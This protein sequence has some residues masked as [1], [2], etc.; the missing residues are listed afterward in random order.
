[1]NILCDNP[2]P[3]CTPG[4]GGG[5][6]PID[7][8]NPFVNLSSETPDADVFIGRRYSIG[9]PPLGSTWYAVGCIGW[10]LSTVSQQAADLCAA[11]Q[12]VLCQSTN[13]PEVNPLTPDDPTNLVDRTVYYNNAQ[14]CDYPCP[15]GTAHRYTVAAG[16]FASTVNQETVDLMAYSYACNQAVNSRICPGDLYP[17]STCANAAYN[18]VITIL[19]ANLPITWTEVTPLPDGLF[20]TTDPSN[21]FISGTPTTPDNYTF[22]LRATDSQDNSNERTYAL[23]V[24]GISTS[25]PLPD[26]TQNSFYSE[27]LEYGG[28]PSGTVVWS[29]TAGTMPTGMTLDTA[30]GELSGTPTVPGLYLLTIGVT[31]DARTC[32]K[33][34]AIT[35]NSASGDCVFGEVTWGAPTYTWQLA[36]G[37]AN[38]GTVTGSAIAPGGAPFEENI[39]FTGTMPYTGSGECAKCTLDMTTLSGDNASVSIVITSDIDGVLLSQQ[40]DQTDG[41]GT[42]E[43]SYKIPASIGATLTIVTNFRG[44]FIDFGPG[45]GS[46]IG[47]ITFCQVDDVAAAIQDVVWTQTGLGGQ[48]PLASI[49][50]AA[51]IGTYDFTFNTTTQIDGFIEMTG[52]ICNPGPAYNITLTM[53]WSAS[54]SV[55][56]GPFTHTIQAKLTINATT[57][58]DTRDLVTGPFTD[59]VV[60]G[61]IPAN[62]TSTLSVNITLDCLPNTSINVVPGAD[63]T[64]TPLTPP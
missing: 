60:V 7:P 16:L 14:Y 55:L 8:D 22:T 20:L 36:S 1:M 62:S 56:G 45:T 35:V 23:N 58:T 27:I 3:T 61:T 29:V 38:G 50:M 44:G 4:P 30:T 43:F 51:G 46:A 19:A 59:L 53:P 10:C 25:S 18:G 33:N 31:D 40:L 57:T 21:A 24:F 26:A 28:T 13:W 15:D 2:C 6:G 34:I 63:V 17:S 42:Y 47:T 48:P 9:D 49:S 52:T 12:A 41:A 39:Q 11:V 5:I 32:T 37:T 54:G 64:I